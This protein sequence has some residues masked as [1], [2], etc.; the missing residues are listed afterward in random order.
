MKAEAPTFKWTGGLV[1]KLD[2]RNHDTEIKAISWG[3]VSHGW[4]SIPKKGLG[5]TSSED[6]ALGDPSTVGS[7]WGE[8]E[9]WYGAYLNLGDQLC[10]LQMAEP[11][12]G[13]LKIIGAQSVEH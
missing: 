6:A 2:H 11:D 9:V 8:Q 12:V 13:L 3:V 4:V 1:R 10:V 7:Q 5:K